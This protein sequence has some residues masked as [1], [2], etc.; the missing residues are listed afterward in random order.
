MTGSNERPSI[1]AT[2]IPEPDNMP[3][4][5]E[6]EIDRTY[7]RPR[8]RPTSL[9]TASKTTSIDPDRNRISPRRT[10]SGTVASELVLAV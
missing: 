6:S 9:S 2:A 7:W 10:N 8:T 1:A 5:V 4:T 3:K